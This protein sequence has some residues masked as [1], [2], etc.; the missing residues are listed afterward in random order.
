MKNMLSQ[1]IMQHYI[2]ILFRRQVTCQMTAKSDQSFQEWQ[3]IESPVFLQ[4]LSLM[5]SLALQK[6]DITLAT[7]NKLVS[8]QTEIFSA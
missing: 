1:I 3:K 6:A 8:K 7:A 4:N 5:L 2:L